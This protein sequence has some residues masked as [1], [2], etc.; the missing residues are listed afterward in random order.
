MSYSWFKVRWLIQKS[1]RLFVRFSEVL[2]VLLKGWMHDWDSLLER[3]FPFLLVKHAR[4]QFYSVPFW[5]KVCLMWSLSMDPTRQLKSGEVDQVGACT[6][7]P[8]SLLPMLGTD[9]SCSH[10]QKGHS[11]VCVVHSRYK[12]QCREQWGYAPS[13]LTGFWLVSWPKLRLV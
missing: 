10:L 7:P 3:F 11:C 1:A 8:S 13:F 12:R 5:L 6:L 9:T 4:Q 2:E